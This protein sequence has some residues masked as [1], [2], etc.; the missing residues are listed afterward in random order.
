MNHAE[1]PIHLIAFIAQDDDRFSRLI[2]LTGIGMDDIRD[3]GTDKNFQ[4]MILDY[5]LSDESLVLE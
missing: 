5:A 4:A 1:I 3:R 2:T